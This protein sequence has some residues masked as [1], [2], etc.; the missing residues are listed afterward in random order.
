M[1]VGGCRLV[2]PGT[3]SHTLGT[4]AYWTTPPPST[5]PQYT[6]ATETYTGGEGRE[7]TTILNTYIILVEA[8]ISYL[9]GVHIH[10]H[11]YVCCT[12]TR[13]LF[14]AMLIGLTNI[15]QSLEQDRMKLSALMFSVQLCGTNKGKEVSGFDWCLVQSVSEQVH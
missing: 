13:L 2:G 1:V 8:S 9:K 12:H 7:G 15:W 14:L 4:P 11:T 5:S 10:V 6:A 3:A